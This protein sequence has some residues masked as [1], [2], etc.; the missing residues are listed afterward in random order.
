MIKKLNYLIA[1][2]LISSSLVSCGEKKVEKEIGLQLWSVRD[3]MRADTEGT[4][5]RIGEIGYSFIEAASYA[6]GKFYGM[7]PIEFKN[8]VNAKGLDFL[9]SHT[10]KALPDSSNWDE[11]MAWWDVCID[12]HAVAGVSYI[13]QPFMCQKGYG[14]TEDLQRYCEYLNIV[15][16]KCNAKGIRF[17]YHNHDGE[18]NNPLEDGSVRYDYMLNNTDPDKVFFQ[19]DIYWII[20]GGK[21]PID[22]FN[23][24]PGRFE[25]W[26]VKDYEEIGASGKIDFEPVFAS[27]EVSGMKHIIVEVE[28]YNFEP[29]VSVEKSFQFLMEA[30]YVK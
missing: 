23:R 18:F 20:V 12:A 22:Y 28:K 4:L 10:G 9:A 25:H 11:I 1:V 8:L 5:Q 21:D 7:D 19:L 26:H 30:D 15:G 29:I 27:A 3:A 6:D 2:L 17:G 14:S 16:E 13:V 24:Y